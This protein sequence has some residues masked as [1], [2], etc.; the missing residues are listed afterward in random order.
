MLFRLLVVAPGHEPTFF[1]KTD[2]LQGP[3]EAVLK[4]RTAEHPPAQTIRG[5][6]AN[7]KGEPVPQAVVSVSTTVIGDTFYGSPPAG[8]DPLAVSDDNGEFSLGSPVPFDAMELQIEARTLARGLFSNVKPG[9]PPRDFMLTEG[10]SITGRVVRD[11]RPV[12]DVV[13][14]ACGTDRTIGNFT[15]DF[16][17]A[18][19]AD[20]RFLLPNLPPNRE[21]FL[22]GLLHSLTNHGVLP[23]RRVK[24]GGDGV[25]LDVGDYVVTPGRRLAGQ[26][27]LSDSEPLP[28]GTRLVVGREEAWDSLAIEL[29]PEGRF[30]LVNLPAGETLNLHVALKGYRPSPR[31]ASYESLNA[32]GLTGRLETDK[33]D[34]VFLLEPGESLPGEWENVPEE[35]RPQNLPLGGIEATHRATLGAI[36]SGRAV[37]AETR[38]PLATFRVTPGTAFDEQGAWVQWRPSRAVAAT[39]GQF[40]VNAGKFDRFAV[41][42]AEAPGFL[43]ARSKAL[44]AGETNWTFEL[45]QGEGPGGMLRGLDGQPLAGVPVYYLGPGEQAYL[46]QTGALRGVQKLAQSE[47]KTDAEGRFQFAPKFGDGEVCVA[48]EAGF[49]RVPAGAVRSQGEVRIQA[50]VKVTGRL[51]RNGKPVAHEPVE[52]QFGGG[53]KPG[54]P[55]LNLQG[56][57]TGDD[58][59]FTFERVPPGEMQLATRQTAPGGGAGWTLVPR[60]TFTAKPGETLD[61]G[62][63]EVRAPDPR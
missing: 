26:V 20:G 19:Q 39:N 10:A 1:P 46:P 32:T 23:V 37:D 53:F 59:R 24:P 18:S 6:V 45:K 33:T 42:L 63:V 30:D 31:N 27:K 12:R 11:G 28:P 60:K 48:T 62:D 36:I 16:S 41:L 47:C 35:E 34:L 49:V 25:T 29:P 21:Y 15:G 43:P 40:S 14:G 61:L 57:K 7:G 55:Y 17:I 50:W 9:G 4:R 3:V 51:V 2:P 56:T 5:R 52:L 22:Y 54:R 8:T 44:K 13:I 58:G 38:A